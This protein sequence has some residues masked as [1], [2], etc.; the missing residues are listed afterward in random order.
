MREIAGVPPLTCPPTSSAT[1]EADWLTGYDLLLFD[2]HGE[3]AD[4][5]WY[6]DAHYPALTAATVRQA[7]LGG[8]VVV[9]LNCHLAD[10]T[11][12]M[13]DALLSAGASYVVAGDGVNY[14]GT[15][16]V[17][18]AGTLAMWVRRFLARNI[19]LPRALWLAKVAL[20]TEM[21]MGHNIEAAADAL[22]FKAFVR[23]P[24]T[25]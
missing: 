6:G 7:N 11:S 21:A 10:S 12:P 25:A 17:M 20:K 4:D 2:L 23:S 9:G 14:A 16:K 24:Q 19:P 5:T 22:K 3:P 13:L 8:A 1:F 18:G 15:T